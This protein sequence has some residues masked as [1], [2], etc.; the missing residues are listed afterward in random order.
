MARLEDALRDALSSLYDPAFEPDPI[1]CDALGCDPQAGV[2]AVQAALV[3]LIRTLEPGPDVPATSRAMRLYRILTLRYV[4]QQTQEKVAE[5][6]AITP[7]HLRREQQDAIAVLAQRITRDDVAVR[8]NGAAGEAS[9]PDAVVGDAAHDAWLSQIKQEVASL[10]KES[11]GFAADVGKALAGVSDITRRLAARYGVSLHVEESPP[12]LTAL[13][14][15][16]A[17]HQVLVAGITELVRQRPT[18]SVSL[19][20]VARGNQ[21]TITITGDVPCYAS[22]DHLMRELLAAHDGSLEVQAHDDRVELLITLPSTTTM[23]VLV[24]DDNDD[25]VH[26]YRRYTAD[27]RYN[28]IHLAEGGAA[29]ETV[30]ALKPDII[31]LDVMLPDVDGW[32]LLSHL[33]EYAASRTIPVIV[34]SVV[35]E[36]ELAL[37][38]GAFSYLP[39]P[40]RRQ[41]F[42]DAL[43]RAAS[44]AESG[45][46]TRPASNGAAC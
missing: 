3:R 19:R 9:L 29:L 35:R 23:S 13:I 34:C 6:L 30:E 14:H 41:Q 26:F 15:P 28:I 36:E 17:L 33:H 11:A 44:L 32:E 7:R 24:I 5:E 39:K 16:S 27:T 45:A 2:E 42:L 20:A 46:S 40:V 25:L 12:N 31:V 8:P 1:L 4:Q 43:G 22:D 37:A 21:V 38:L 10:R 18:T